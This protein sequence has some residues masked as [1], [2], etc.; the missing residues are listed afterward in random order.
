M[1]NLLILGNQQNME[2]IQVSV[3]TS[4][5]FPDD[6]TYVYKLIN[7]YRTQFNARDIQIEVSRFS[8]YAF[9]GN[10]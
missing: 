2:Q 7:V 10:V 6:L 4:Q 8:N 3:T 5:N 9:A 1:D